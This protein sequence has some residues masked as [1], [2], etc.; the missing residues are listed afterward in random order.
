MPSRGRPPS[1]RGSIRAVKDQH[2]KIIRYEATINLGKDEMGTYRRQ[3]IAGQTK[4][5]VQT[6]LDT[7]VQRLSAQTTTRRS[8]TTLAFFDEWL[9]YI[10]EH[11]RVGTYHS[12]EITTRLH[13]RPQLPAGRLI[14]LNTQ[15]VRRIIHS[16]RVAKGPSRTLEYTASVLKRALEKAVEWGYIAT[17]PAKGVLAVEDYVKRE[18]RTLSSDE[19]Q[20]LL[21]T[22]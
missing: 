9:A 3:V 14:D 16:V 12:Y 7:E 11:Q 19:V 17:N 13:I 8:I 10:Q 5:E 4:R 6:R 20:Q 15:D 18:P 2:G 22:A 1:L 21:Q